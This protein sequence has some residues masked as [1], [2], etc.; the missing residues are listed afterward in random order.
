MLTQVKWLTKGLVPFT[1]TGPVYLS[2]KQPSQG[3][4]V[5]QPWIYKQLWPLR[6]QRI[7]DEE[8]RRRQGRTRVKPPSKSS[9][10][11]ILKQQAFWSKISSDQLLVSCLTSLPQANTMESTGLV[12]RAGTPS[13]VK[14]TNLASSSSVPRALGLGSTP[15]LTERY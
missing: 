9:F 10:P 11:V 3:N 7:Q 6:K 2:P 14:F 12:W 15:E 4:S 8:E 13:I 5:H 1:L